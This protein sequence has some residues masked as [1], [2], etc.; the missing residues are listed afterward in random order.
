MNPDIIKF[1]GYTDKGNMLMGGFFTAHDTYGLHTDFFMSLFLE[2]GYSVSVPYFQCE[3]LLSP[4]RDPDI[5][6][7]LLDVAYKEARIPFDLDKIRDKMMSYFN[8]EM[9]R[10][11][12]LNGFEFPLQEFSK[13]MIKKY[14]ENGLNTTRKLKEEIQTAIDKTYK[15]E[16]KNDY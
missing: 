5:I 4:Y 15:K 16:N 6:W 11:N 10:M 12:D 1:L 13:R 9:A 2:K 14:E 3:C 7:P 8:S